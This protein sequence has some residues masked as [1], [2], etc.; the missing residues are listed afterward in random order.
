[1]VYGIGHSLSNPSATHASLASGGAF[2]QLD[3]HWRQWANE[4]SIAECR[5]VALERLQ[6]CLAQQSSCLDLS[7]LFLASI[8]D[9]L[10]E[11]VT[12]LNLAG[13]R[14]ACLPEHLP[15]GLKTLE[16]SDNEGL[17]LTHIPDGLRELEAE[18]LNLERLP[19]LPNSLTVCNVAHNDLRQLPDLPASLRTLE[20]G[21]NQLRKLPEL[22]DSL[23]YCDVPH[24]KLKRL[25]GL[26]AALIELDVSGNRLKRLPDLH[27]RLELLDVSGN[28]L[29]ALPRL[30]A[31]LQR[32]Y[33]DR[34]SLEALDDLPESLT[35]LDVCDNE[36]TVLPERVIER[37]A[38]LRTAALE[39]NSW[40]PEIEAALERVRSDRSGPAEPTINASPDG[41]AR[42]RPL[43]DAV[44]DWLP[45]EGAEQAL[46]AWSEVSNAE[47]KVQAFSAFLDRLGYVAFAK[48]NP[49]FQAAVGQWLIALGQEPELRQA[50]FELAYDATQTCEDRVALTW[51][52]LQRLS[53]SHAISGATPDTPKDQLLQWVREVCALSLL[54]EIAATKVEEMVLKV[55]K[56]YPFLDHEQARKRVEEIEVHLAY[57]T[58]LAQA[59]DLRT[60]VRNM[61]FG[62]LS[63]VNA[64]DL[65]AASAHVTAFL[66]GPK[67]HAWMNNWQPWQ[68][69]LE[70]LYPQ[71]YAEAHEMRSD[72][73]LDP[74]LYSK[75]LAEIKL[76]ENLRTD[77]QANQILA[78]Y[79]TDKYL[80]PLT[81]M[82]LAP[83]GEAAASHAPGQIESTRL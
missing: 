15:S 61:K 68:T 17:R 81:R 31:S 11:H 32:L 79:L 16:V 19:R 8:P 57:P 37:I 3:A 6:E 70:K 50:S 26:P 58:A 53:L 39:R 27:D 5:G 4:G 20:A 9:R 60:P 65:K 12:V 71:R 35:E 18:R 2:A 14:L 34:N 29:R 82:A 25:P 72:F 67:F 10:P 47:R 48:K 76:I 38:Q 41:H 13:N 43:R 46:I 30:P 21:R 44:A 59:L 54:E 36:L 22:P 78:T 49:A 45:S 42:A 69:V 40:R 62:A 28:D 74:D 55:R 1:M 24:N 83:A 80:A 56:A 66:N 63:G 64:A 7:D 75:A 52:Q 23:K 73:Y 51:N 33:A 77:H